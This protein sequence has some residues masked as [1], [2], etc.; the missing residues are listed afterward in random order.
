MNQS[1][2]EEAVFGSLRVFDK[3]IFIFSKWC[4]CIFWWRRPISRS[5]KK[6]FKPSQTANH[7]RVYFIH[8]IEKYSKQKY[9]TKIN[10]LFS[11]S[12]I[13]SFRTWEHLLNMEL[14]KWWFENM[15]IWL[16]PKIRK[17]RNPT[18]IFWFWT[19]TFQLFRTI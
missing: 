4:R 8:L 17:F 13:E 2:N 7:H 6:T 15:R 19:E 16:L 3:R 14:H 10:K 9:S 18:K 1:T 12:R 11:I 5:L